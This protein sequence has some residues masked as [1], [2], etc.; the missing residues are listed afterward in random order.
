MVIATFNPEILSL[1]L[2]ATKILVV[3]LLSLIPIS[4]IDYSLKLSRDGNYVVAALNIKWENKKVFSQK[5]LDGSSYFYVGVITI[6][7][8]FVIYSIITSL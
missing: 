4:L 3:I 2:H 5:L 7:I 8:A 6:I 1:S